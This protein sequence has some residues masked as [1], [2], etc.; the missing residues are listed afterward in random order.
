MAAQQRKLFAFAHL[1]GGFVPAGRLTLTEEAGQ[2]LASS[3]AYGL[4]YL[5]RPGRF[6]VDPVSLSLDDV[7][8]VRGAELMPLG[9]LALF[10]GIRDAA[11]DAWGRRVIE[12]RHKVPANSLPESVYLLE[13]G[14]DR[15]GAL[16][17]RESLES[18]P[19]RGVNEVHSLGYM[20]ETA[21][22]IDQGEEIPARLTDFFGSGPGA[23]GARPKAAVRDE[24]GLL[25]LA[26]FPSRGDAFD[27][28]TAEA[29]T[30]RLARECGL[31]AP[32]AKVMDV[33]GTPVLLVRRFDRYWCEPDAHPTDGLVLHE[34]R[35]DA[36]LAERRLPFASA[37]TLLACDEFDARRRSYVE[38]AQA[39]RRHVQ[40]DRVR[41]DNRELFG[42]MAFN[43][44]VSN[45]DDHL[46][47]HGFT[48]DPRSQGW[49]L[50]PLYDVVPRPGVA[51]ERLLHLGVGDQGKAATLDNAM[52][53]HEAFGLDQH[54]A[55]EVLRR[56]WG[57]VRQW[58]TVFETCG[59]PGALID[60]V[61][62]AFRKLEDI[63][64]PGLVKKIRQ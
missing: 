1:D 18:P 23:G 9:G 19:T 11:P 26:K 29:A 20:L 36:G 6:P 46:R 43:I 33:G 55:I 32:E 48:R 37:L 64:S 45:D 17:M 39:I 16:D 7:D 8:R 3:F 15:V 34:T 2:V 31:D 61:H 54:Q 21:D 24:T 13:A 25:W 35:P 12:A 5:E 41:A 40:V 60:K 44:F 47:N 51:Y 4:R 14:S 62:T 50:S 59:A 63:A 27:M 57:G 28:A 38:I 58:V 42:R 53:R 30:L 56:V 22:R 10:G 52:T 49:A